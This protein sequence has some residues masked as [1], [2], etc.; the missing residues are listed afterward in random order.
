MAT[1]SID[2]S[3][4]TR[5]GN[6]EDVEQGHARK[7]NHDRWLINTIFKVL[8]PF[9]GW[10]S[11][12]CCLLLKFHLTSKLYFH[13]TFKVNLL[14]LKRKVNACDVES[15][16]CPLVFVFNV[17]MLFCLSACSSLFYVCNEILYTLWPW[18][19]VKVNKI[20]MV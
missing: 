5:E 9:S 16:M 7:I 17:V 11:L 18:L 3:G 15:C 10:K 14:C 1:C 13:L 20:S 12:F 19:S 6:L 8:F 2:A 4:P